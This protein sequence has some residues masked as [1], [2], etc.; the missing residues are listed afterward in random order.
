MVPSRKRVDKAVDLIE[1]LV[2]IDKRYTL[3]I[4]GKMPEEYAWLNDREE[5]KEYFDGVYRRIEANP[6]LKQHIQFL[7]FVDDIHNF[8]SSVGHVISMSDFESFHL[9]LADGPINGA[10][11]HTLPWSGSDSIYTDL[12]IREDVDEMAEQIH[13][14][15]LSNKTAYHAYLQS[16]HLIWQMQPERIALGIISAMAGE[17]S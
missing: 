11:A 8:F 14:L 5:E 4:V 10:A 13:S 1:K 15:N 16:K 7:G 3:K 2:A 9:T 12:W 6:I 17:E